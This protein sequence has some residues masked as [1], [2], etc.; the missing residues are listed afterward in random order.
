MQMSVPMKRSCLWLLCCLMSLFSSC[1]KDEFKPLPDFSLSNLDHTVPLDT[2]HRALFEGIYELVE[3]DDHFGQQLAGKWADGYLCLF[4][5]SDGKFMN[6][7]AG[8]NAVDSSFRMAGFWHDPL[9]P[10]Q[11]QIQ[12]TISRADGAD[13]IRAQLSNSFVLRGYRENDPGRTITLRYKR[14][15]SAAVLSRYFVLTAHRGG[16]RNSDNLPYAENSL[17]LVKHAGQ[18]GATGVEIDIRLSRDKV[19]II[20]HDPDINTRLTLKKPAGRRYPPVQR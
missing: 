5:Q 19:P 12:F 18:F 3:G 6:L 8:Y 4:G 9:Q 16:G 15:F 1:I 2:A 20:Y 11:G 13:S 10:E 17:N 7:Q 14:P